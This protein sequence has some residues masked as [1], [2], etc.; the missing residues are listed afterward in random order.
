MTIRVRSCL[1][2]VCFATAAAGRAFASRGRLGGGEDLD[3]SLGRIVVALVISIIVA[4][5]AVL[6]IRQRTGRTDIRAVFSR[7]ELRPREIE[8]V[9]TRRLSPHAD[10]CLVRHGGRQYLL[11]LMAGAAQLLSE[12]SP[13]TRPEA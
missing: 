1:V 13:E 12:T 10:I 9:E 2:A 5:L 3:V 11:L 7:F 4:A 8:V 6:F